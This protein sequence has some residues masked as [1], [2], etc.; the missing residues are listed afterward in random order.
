MSNVNKEIDAAIDER[1]E[2]VYNLPGYIKIALQTDRPEM[3]NAQLVE[4]HAGPGREMSLDQQVEIVRLVRDLIADRVQNKVRLTELLTTI[5]AIR[6]HGEGL[7]GMAER[8]VVTIEEC[9]VSA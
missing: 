3:I 8:I 6:T 7:I 4:M 5:K 1:T 2:G 9:G